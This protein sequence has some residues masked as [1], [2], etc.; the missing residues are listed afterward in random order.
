MIPEK[1]AFIFVLAFFLIVFIQSG[2]DKVFD[3]K[4]NL[5]FL[6]DSLGSFFSKPLITLALISVTILELISGLLCL[7]GIVDV[8]FNDSNFIGLIGMIIG[9]IALLILLFGQRVSK[10]YDGAKTIAIY[11]ILAMIGIVLA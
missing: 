8:I 6:N 3:Y 9:S 4:G 10:N 2:L 1:I 11:F 7:I 5:S